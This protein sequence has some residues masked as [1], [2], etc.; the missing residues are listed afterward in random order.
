MSKEI[1]TI[2]FTKKSAENFF[3][4][5]KNN[6]VRR[7]LDTR[8]NNTGQL[9]GFSKKEDLKYFCKTLISAEYI[10]WEE[11]APEDSMLSAFKKKLISWETYA[12]EYASLLERRKIERQLSLVSDLNSCLLCSEAK[13]KKCHRSILAE[14]KKKK[15]GGS[16]KVKHLT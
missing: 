16:F 14:K 12:N 11:S 2:G 3:S 8:L 9:A 5:L 7:I 1:Y 10:H 4:L 13:P 15:S 6:D